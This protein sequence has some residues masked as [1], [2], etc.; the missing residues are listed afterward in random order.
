[1]ECADV[2][3]TSCTWTF[4]AQPATLSQLA[5]QKRRLSCEDGQ[6]GV[7]CCWQG[8]PG[9]HE[10][11][12]LHWPIH[13]LPPMRTREQ[14]YPFGD[15]THVRCT[16]QRMLRLATANVVGFTTVDNDK[17]FGFVTSKNACI[18]TVLLASKPQHWKCM[19]EAKCGISSTN[20]SFAC[21]AA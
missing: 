2:S 12:A 3:I 5:I 14:H 10:H 15:L 13:F 20:I 8:L 7:T 11:G 9:M 19:C 4:G 16:P 6:A 18:L 1:M 17:L 21:Q